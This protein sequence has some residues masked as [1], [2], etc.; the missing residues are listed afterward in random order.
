MVRGLFINVH[1]YVQ[2]NFFLARPLS[3]VVRQFRK[4]N[5]PQLNPTS[6]RRR[7]SKTSTYDDEVVLGQLPCC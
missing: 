6:L 4:R 7:T 5:A 3:V 2:R 1:I